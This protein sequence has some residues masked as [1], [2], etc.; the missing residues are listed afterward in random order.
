MFSGKDVPGFYLK[1][2]LSNHFKPYTTGLLIL[3]ELV[4]N[5]PELLSDNNLKSQS[6]NMFNK[7]TGTGKILKAIESNLPNEM[8]V[9]L[10]N[11]GLIDFLNIRTKYLL[12]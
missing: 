10:A 9:T 2:N 3:N 6:I 12:Y 11:D 7:V 4:K 5:N 8:I 1:F